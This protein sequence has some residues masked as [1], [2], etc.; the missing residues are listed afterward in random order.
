MN[1]AHSVFGLT[2]LCYMNPPH[3]VSWTK[4]LDKH[5]LAVHQP[6]YQPLEKSSL[7]PSYP[8]L[9]SGQLQ[10]TRNSRCK[11]WKV[12]SKPLTHM[13][14]TS[15]STLVI[16]FNLLYIAKEQVPQGNQEEETRWA[17]LIVGPAVFIHNGR[18]WESGVDWELPESGQLGDTHLVIIICEAK[19]WKRHKSGQ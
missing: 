3:K 18:K 9:T 5:S 12:V 8:R 2:Y 19:Q 10:P 17:G 11:N 4:L 15:R 6:N 13:S 14:K 1:K 16:T 7:K